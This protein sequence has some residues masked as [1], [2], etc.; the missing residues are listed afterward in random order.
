M[1]QAPPFVLAHRIASNRTV[2]GLH[3][4]VDSLAGAVVGAQLG[5]ALTAVA[6]GSELPEPVELRNY[7]GTNCDGVW[8]QTPDFSLSALHDLLPG[9]G[10]ATS[11]AAV[12]AWIWEKAATEW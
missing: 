11:D 9:V 6:T 10:S 12:L 8:K 3:F 1:R 2:A 5:D 7:A 4:P